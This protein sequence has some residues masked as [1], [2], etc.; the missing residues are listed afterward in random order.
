MD[1]TRQ[2]DQKLEALRGLAILLVVAYHVD[3]WLPGQP[4]GF[5]AGLKHILGFIRMPLF[6][7]I[8]GAVYALRPFIPGNGLKFLGGKARRLLVPMITVGVFAFLFKSSPPYFESLPKIL[9]AWRLLLFPHYQFWYLQALFLI[10]LIIIL[11]ESG[12]W[13][14]TIGWWLSTLS[15]TTLLALLARPAALATVDF[16]LSLDGL[17]FLLPYFVFGLGLGRFKQ[18]WQSPLFTVVAALLAGLGL[19]LQILAQLGRLTIADRKGSLFYLCLSLASVFLL[20]KIRWKAAWLAR[21]GSFSYSIFL[22]HVYAVMAVG[23]ILSTLGLN[24]APAWRFGILLLSG[25]SLPILVHLLLKRF[26]LTRRL[27]LGL[28]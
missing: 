1:P 15:L 3:V 4:P 27:F 28:R 11:L 23:I 8:S 13:L 5:Y 10:F 17:L 7:C 2:K 12:K 24:L 25:L 22:F 26:A 16:P 20:F 19:T 9:R 6:A 14:K 18:L 21:L